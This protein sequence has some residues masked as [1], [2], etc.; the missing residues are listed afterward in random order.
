MKNKMCFDFEKIKCRTLRTLCPLWFNLVLLLVL[1]VGLSSCF[2]I[3]KDMGLVTVPDLQQRVGITGTQDNPTP[4]D[5]F[6]RYDLVMA[7]NECR[8]FTMKVP[9]QWY[10]KVYLTAAN[11]E[12]A[13]RGSLAAAIAPANPPWSPLPATS[14][15]KSFD[16]AGR[17]GIQAVLAV[18]NTQADRLAYF[19]LC[20]DGAPLHITI[21][22]EV[23][24]T[25][26]LLGPNSS[27]PVTTNGD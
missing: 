10:W 22:S 4:L 2:G 12:E 26:A 25:R 15:Q 18:G 23:S 21:Q 3:D 9:S 5:P 20:Q 19:Q 8:F 24:A 14:F 17:E 13:R 16:L 11:H 7:A 6:K 1:G 27:Q